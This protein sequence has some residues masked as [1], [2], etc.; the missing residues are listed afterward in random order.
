MLEVP[1]LPFGKHRQ[2]QELQ[3]HMP[4]SVLE[5]VVVSSPKLPLSDY[6]TPEAVVR[7]AA[8]DAAQE[9]L[10]NPVPNT[11]RQITVASV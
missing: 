9:G 2:L 11:Q 1:S 5:L 7:D 8:I 6:L 3:G 10:H 4:S